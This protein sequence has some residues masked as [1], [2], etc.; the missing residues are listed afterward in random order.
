MSTKKTQLFLALTA[1]AGLSFLASSAHAFDG[2][3]TFN[4]EVTTQTCAPTTGTKNLVVPMETVSAVELAGSAGAPIKL[5]PFSIMLTGC[6]PSSGNVLIAFNSAG[7]LDSDTNQLT[8]DAGGATNV[9]IRLVNASDS[10]KILVGAEPESQNSE[11]ASIGT[12]GT[13]TLNY[14]AGYVQI[15]ADMA[16]AGAVTAKAE[17]TITYQ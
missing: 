4:G 17:Y 9:Q 3:I 2:T 14:K 15:G 5:T 7:N 1:A 16:T 13:V 8:P 10:S 11:P 6:T 12:D